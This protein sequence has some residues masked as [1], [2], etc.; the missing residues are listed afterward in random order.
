M[1]VKKTWERRRS[2]RFGPRQAMFNLGTGRQRPQ[3]LDIYEGWFLLGLLP[4]YIRRD[5]TPL[6]DF[7][8]P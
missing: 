4:L 3:Y 8:D 6:L 7:A 1:L 2:D 5:R